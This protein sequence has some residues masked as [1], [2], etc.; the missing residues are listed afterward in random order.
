MIARKIAAA[1]LAL[2]ST[3][4]TS[5][6]A[7]SYSYFD[8]GDAVNPNSHAAVSNDIYVR[9]FGWAWGDVKYGR[10]ESPPPSDGRQARESGVPDPR[11]LTPGQLSPQ[12]NAQPRQPRGKISMNL[13]AQSSAQWP[14]YRLGEEPG[15]GGEPASLMRPGG[16]ER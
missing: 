8:R 9:S 6:L 11:D 13:A 15:L 16:I 2:L 3:A 14:A 1:A 10:D 7:G 5:A 4:A 12:N